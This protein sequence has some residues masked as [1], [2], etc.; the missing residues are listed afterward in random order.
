ML[1]SSVHAQDV[2]F[3]QNHFMPAYTNPAYSTLFN[4]DFRFSGIIRNQWKSVTTPYTSTALGF[5]GKLQKQYLNNVNLGGGLVFVSDNAG[6]SQ[7]STFGSL[8]NINASIN[9]GNDSVHFIYFGIQPGIFQRNI[10]F[11]KLKFDSQFDGDIYDPTLPNGEQFGTSSFAYFDIGA[12]LAWHFVVNDRLNTTMGYSYQHMNEANQTFFDNVE[13]PLPHKSSITADANYIINDL[14]SVHPKILY[15]KQ[16]SFHQVL[17]GGL[18]SY[19]MQ[20]SRF[21]NTVLQSGVLY[22]SKDAFSV[23]MGYKFNNYNVGIAYDVNVSTLSQASNGK[24]AIEF[25][26]NYIISTV[27]P[28]STRAKVCPIY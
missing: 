20:N 8:F 3:S 1:G 2:H 10:N 21:E 13:V 9:P 23:L 26:I 22:R 16:N 7:Y 12:G 24:G 28:I 18:V 27:K 15:Q 6:D 25:G 17:T 11:D 14:F 19:S 4:G 5:D